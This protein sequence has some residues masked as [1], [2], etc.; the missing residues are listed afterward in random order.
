MIVSRK[1]AIVI[2]IYYTVF[3]QSD[4][5]S[6]GWSLEAEELPEWSALKWS[7]A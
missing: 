4:V 1:Q 7:K 6:G 5:D 3:F 2:V